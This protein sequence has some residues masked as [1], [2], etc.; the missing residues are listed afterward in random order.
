M[1]GP[2]RDALSARCN[3]DR[4]APTADGA[5]ACASAAV[6]M[7]AACPFPCR[8][9][10]PI[11]VERLAEA[12]AAAGRE[13]HVVAYHYGGATRDDALAQ[14]GA[15]YRLH[16]T[17]WLPG[18]WDPAPG[19]GL[20]K[21]LLLDPL[22]V[23]RTLGVVRRHGVRLLHAHHYEGLLVALAVRTLSPVVVVYDAH[24]LLGEELGYYGPRMLKRPLEAVGAFLD[25]ALPRRADHVISV[26]DDI[27]DFL[28]AEGRVDAPM[29]IVG[30]GIEAKVER[31]IAEAR[32]RA[33]DPV[34][35]RVVFAG[36]LAAYQGVSLL[37]RAFAMAAARRP[38]AELVLVC[39]GP[40]DTLLGEAA[41]LG[42][43][44]R[45]RAVASE[46]AGL[47]RELA[48]AQVLANPRV[49]CP[50]YPRKLLN[51]MAAGRGIVSFASSAKH[52]RHGV[53]A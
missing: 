38:R 21:M 10:T 37:L 45:V 18:R 40:H 49:R 16:R 30:N 39:A 8:R 47:W 22:L 35:E 36:N 24:T 48:A 42:L 50:G 29:T 23:A 7:V 1:H 51:Y 44:G 4:H 20:G 14:R 25:R 26:S 43:Q 11:R 53:D 31:L 41:A 52:L 32:R 13:V 9:G 17:P 15:G 34:P 5:G 27:H 3:L 6:A 28:A 12:L 19:P 46:R 33:P 2:D